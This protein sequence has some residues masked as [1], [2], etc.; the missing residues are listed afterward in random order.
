AIDRSAQTA[1][2]A[3]RRPGPPRPEPAA[4]D[5]GRRSVVVVATVALAAL[6][7]FIANRVDDGSPPIDELTPAPAAASS[8]SA[9]SAPPSSLPGDPDM[10]AHHVARPPG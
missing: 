9:T 8:T 6:A 5:G 7:V 3:H 1:A 2:T 10:S 4:V